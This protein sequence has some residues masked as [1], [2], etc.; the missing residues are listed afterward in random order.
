MGRANTRKTMAKARKMVTMAAKR[1]ARMVTKVEK[2]KVIMVQ[3]MVTMVE[4]IKVSRMTSRAQVV[5]VQ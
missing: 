5:V 1:S 4:K 3:I 2:I